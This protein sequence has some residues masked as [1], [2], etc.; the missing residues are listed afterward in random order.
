MKIPFLTEATISGVSSI[1]N[2]VMLVLT[3]VLFVIIAIGD[4]KSVV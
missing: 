4:R 3:I 1:I 2:T